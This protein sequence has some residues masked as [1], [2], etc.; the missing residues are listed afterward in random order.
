M[1][2]LSA[3]D[4]FTYAVHA[5]KSLLL[6]DTGILAISGDLAFL[7]IFSIITMTIATLSFRR[8]L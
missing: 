3:A 2:V 4:P 8:S 1:Q 7:I 6:K 5:L